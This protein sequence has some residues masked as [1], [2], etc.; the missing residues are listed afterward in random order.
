[1]SPMLF[2]LYLKNVFHIALEQVDQEIKV[3]GKPINNLLYAD[4]TATMAGTIKD[5]Q[6]IVNAINEVRIQYGF[7]MNVK[8]TE[9]MIVSRERKTLTYNFANK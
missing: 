3:N 9:F 2:N 7:I 6:S 5:R 1:M 4:D 8:K